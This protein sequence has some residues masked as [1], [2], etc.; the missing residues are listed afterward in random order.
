MAANT[1][2]G[3]AGTKT[4]DGSGA[5]SLTS[6]LGSNQLGEQLQGLASAMADRGVSV[7]T[8]RLDGLTDKMSG[9]T[10]KTVKKRAKGDSAPKAALKAASKPSKTAG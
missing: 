3:S 5:E 9:A 10:G 7:V 8:D 2:D 1:R 4:G 6:Q